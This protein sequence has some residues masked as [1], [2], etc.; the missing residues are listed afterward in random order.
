[1]VW[2]ANVLPIFYYNDL[3][4]SRIGDRIGLNLFEQRYQVMCQRM[5]A[6]PYFLFMP[7]LEDYM[8]RAGDVGF[9]VRVESCQRSRGG[10][11]SI[12]GYA[13]TLVAISCTWVEPRTY[14]LH[15]GLFWRLDPSVGALSMP[16]TT[17]LLQSLGASGWQAQRDED[18]RTK[19]RYEKA[20]IVLG[21]NWPDRFFLLLFESVPSE[22]VQR[23]LTSAWRA[24]D[25]RTRQRIRPEELLEKAAYRLPDQEK[26]RPL[27]EICDTALHLLRTDG[28]AVVALL[29]GLP[30]E[31]VWASVLRPARLT[32]VGN[33]PADLSSAQLSL[34]GVEPGVIAES[35]PRV[36][37]PRQPTSGIVANNG[38]N[39]HFVALPSMLRVSSE[40]GD[41]VLKLLRWRLNRLGLRI[42]LRGRERGHG[43]LG[44]L[45]DDPWRLICEFVA[46]E[47]AAS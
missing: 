9:I 40:S 34:C 21:A 41:L 30:S 26:G 18:F 46:K 1:M 23:S 44:S 11:Y 14:G 29:N 24:L 13:E 42:F 33:M 32:A 37:V 17:A 43:F 28:A 45:E 3:L 16:E 47:P 7:N 6:Q 35:F 12:V 39:V 20:T 36:A 38:T 8:C 31:G 10:T 2:E 25:P 27:T 22:E 5:A 4:I 15:H 19:I